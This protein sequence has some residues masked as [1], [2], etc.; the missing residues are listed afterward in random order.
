MLDGTKHFFFPVQFFL[1]GKKF[2]SPRPNPDVWDPQWPICHE[3][4][5][6][7]GDLGLFESAVHIILY[8][9]KY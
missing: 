6:I 2:L 7:S 5:D 8:N 4:D 1:F 9:I 3:S